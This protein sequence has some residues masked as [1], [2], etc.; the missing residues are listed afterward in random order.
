MIRI[1]RVHWRAGG[2]GLKSLGKYLGKQGQARLSYRLIIIYS[3][4]HIFAFLRLRNAFLCI[5]NTFYVR[6]NSKLLAH[7]GE[8][9]SGKYLEMEKYLAREEDVGGEEKRMDFSADGR[10]E[11]WEQKTLE[12]DIHKKVTFIRFCTMNNEHTH[13]GRPF[14]SFSRFASE[15]LCLVCTSSNMNS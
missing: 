11:S 4:A 8:G 10:K 3:Y 1:H 15:K 6:Q 2:S 7:K 12:E 5:Q 14:G 9:Q 13:L